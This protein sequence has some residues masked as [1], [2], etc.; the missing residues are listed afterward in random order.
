MK[1][2]LCLFALTAGLACLLSPSDR[3]PLI[4]QA[5]KGN[6]AQLQKR[7]NDLQGD[8]RERDAKIKQLQA[9]LSREKKDDKG[10]DAKI[11]DLN[12]K[13]Q[14]LQKQLGSAKK[15]DKGDDAKIL[16]LNKKLKSQEAK[17]AELQTE[18][19]KAPAA[20]KTALVHSVIFKLK[21]GGDEKA[22]KKALDDAGK[23]LAKIDGVR[24][25]WFG[26]PSANAAAGAVT[27]YQY[28]MCVVL[29][30]A[31]ALQRLLADPSYK[32]LEK[33]FEKPTV[34]DFGK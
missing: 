30:D 27:D 19:K 34:Y 7:I 21:D 33:R 12:N 4:A 22:A 5:K 17:I 11:R 10:D 16:E 24:N 13:I 23:T 32:N 9:Q 15:D 26:K 28:G 3:A 8:V 29:D 25:L 2:S 31:P 20:T 1:L 14:M 18:L 6:D